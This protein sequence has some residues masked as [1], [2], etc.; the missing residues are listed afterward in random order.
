VKKFAAFAA[1]TLIAIGLV[2]VVPE[3][4]IHALPGDSTGACTEST[5]GTVVC[6]TSANGG[7]GTWT[8]PV[9]VLVA[10]FDV[11]GATGGSYV[12]SSTTAGG[13]GGDTTASGVGVSSATTY[14]IAVGNRGGDGE[15]RCLG[16]GAGPGGSPGGGDGAR[17][18]T[19][20]GTFTCF[21]GGGGGGASVVATDTVSSDVTSWLVAAGGGGGAG[22]GGTGGTGGG[23]SGGNGSGSGAGGA[24]GQD[25]STGSQQHLQGSD[26][27]DLFGGTGGGGGGGGG[28]VG[29]GGASASTRA[30]GRSE[31][32]RVGK[33]CRSRWSPYH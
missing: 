32:R 21:N 31:E 24:G 18:C 6:S 23:T 5:P 11:Q 7:V 15:D 29:G 17:S 30:R 4:P 33:E 25:T 8:P 13:K 2:A 22:R 26:G 12:A 9:G 10:S 14:H 20:S 19:T 16:C 3:G 28:Y 27:A 1:S